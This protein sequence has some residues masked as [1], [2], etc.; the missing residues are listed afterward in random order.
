ME[1]EQIAI[2]GAGSVRCMPA[3]AGALAS[4]FG[5]RPLEVRLFDGD[6][7]RLDLLDRYCRLLFTFNRAGHT[8]SA[9]LDPVEA[10]DGVERIVLCVGQNCAIK[11]FRAA[12]KGGVAT[13]DGVGLV[14]QLVE[15]L[16]ASIPDRVEVLSLLGERFAVPL[17]R[18]R[19]LDW[20]PPPSAKV[21]TAVPHQLLRFLNGEE[22][23]H[24]L[25]ADATNSPVK[26]WLEDLDSAP[27][28]LG[29]REV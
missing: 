29:N 27:V 14:E 26:A 18:Y 23:P 21:R 6:E 11:Y 16:A 1:P 2:L 3:V 13:G 24:A 20:P 25:L 28:V 15:V 5:E 8:L 9:T 17:P 19:Q 10:I 12:R 4:F 22:Y 7:E